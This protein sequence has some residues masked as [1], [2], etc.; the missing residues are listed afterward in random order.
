M[1]KK[2]SEISF[3]RVFYLLF[4]TKTLNIKIKKKIT[5]PI[6]VLMVALTGG[7]K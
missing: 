5:F 2:E 4:S 3:F 1:I 7:S 6:R